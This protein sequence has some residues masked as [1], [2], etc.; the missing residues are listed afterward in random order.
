M[1]RMSRKIFWLLFGVL[2]I[3][4]GGNA[5]SAQIINAASCNSADVQKSFN[6]VNPLTTTVNIPAGTCTW[7]TQVTLTV[8]S[9]STTLSILGAGNLTTTGGGDAT[10]IVDNYASENPLLVITTGSTSSYFRLAGITLEGGS[11]GVKYNGILNILGPSHSVRLDHSHLDAATYNPANNSALVRFNG[12]TEGVTDHNI[13]D[14]P[15][16]GV[17]NAVQVWFDGYSGNTQGFGDASFATATALG[18][19][20]FMFVENN[21]FNNGFVDDCYAG[22]KWVIRYNT[23]NS[24]TTQTHPTGGAGRIRGCRA[25]ELYNNTFIG[26]NSNPTNA[27]LFLS[28]GTGVIWGNIAP[29]GYEEFVSGHVDLAENNTYPQSSPPNGWGYCGTAQTGISSNWNENTNSSGYACLDQLGRGIGDL[30]SGAFPTACDQTSGGCAAGTFTGT[31]PNQALEPIYEWMDTWGAV[32]GYPYPFWNQYDV[33][34]TTNRDYY[35]WCNAS[36]S[37]GCT[38]FTGATGTGSGLLASRPSTCTAGVAYWV[39]DTQTLYK[40]ANTNT[41]TTYY[42]PYTYPHPLD[43]TSSSATLPA[44]PTGLTGEVN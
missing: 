39:T 35:L 11:G 17:G 33:V 36:S 30:L 38:S 41:W 43:V 1:T 27:G 44:A 19:N 22:G 20:D 12:W 6:R 34:A 32:P 37:T 31:W 5:A 23:I 24:S 9:G 13:F 3:F 29:A 14:E 26:S 16:G 21:T 2:S 42:T 15:S 4:F 10:I 18:S 7:T 25:F 40:C 8:P 28:N